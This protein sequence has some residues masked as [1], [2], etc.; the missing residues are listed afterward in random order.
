MWLVGVLTISLL[1]VYCWFQKLQ[2][3]NNQLKMQFE[4]IMMLR[5]LIEF[6]R[7]HRRFCHQKLVHPS[8]NVEFDESVNV[9]THIM[10]E[11]LT[12]LIHQAESNHKPMF[13]I[14]RKEIQ[15]LLTECHEYNLQR[16]QAV[17]GRIIRHIMYLIDDVMSMALLNSE[18]KHAFKQYQTAWP[19]I[20]NSLD[21]L[22]RFRWMIEH[23][24]IKS[25]IY[26]RDLKIN[27]K[28]IQR[29][30]GQIQMLSLQHP[31]TW[32]I[33]KLLTNFQAHSFETHDEKGLREGLYGYSFQVSDTIFQYFDL[34]L[35]DIADE[36]AIEAPSLTACLADHDCS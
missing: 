26:Q 7:Y 18:K 16:S 14:L 25:S 17:H 15:S 34:I 28:M 24:P 33:E 19:I 29:R 12:A 4:Q 22:Q 23:Y 11:T 32:P 1:A 13:R 21:N 35:A 6:I 27:I 20:L 30:L 36:L 8:K 31:P 3:N 5:Q 10:K 2:K 9:K